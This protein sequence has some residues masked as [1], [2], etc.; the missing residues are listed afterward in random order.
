M[1]SIC[2]RKPVE[3]RETFY[4]DPVVYSVLYCKVWFEAE[5]QLRQWRLET[6]A[7]VHCHLPDHKLFITFRLSTINSSLNAR[8]LNI[9][10]SP[11]MVVQYT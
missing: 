11:N 3:F 6:I 8:V 1:T 9:F 10:I 4:S 2:A 7:Y 5:M